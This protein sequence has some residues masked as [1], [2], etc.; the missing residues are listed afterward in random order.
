MNRV[1]FLGLHE[2]RLHVLL[3]VEVGHLVRRLH[4]EERLELGVRDDLATVGGVLEVVVLDVGRDELGHIRASH[5]GVLRHTEE[6]GEFLG[7]RRRLHEATRGTRA[8]V[9]V[10]LG[11]GLVHGAG[12]LEHLLLKGLEVALELV[13]RKGESLDALGET[14]EDF[15]HGALNG[16]DRLFR[17]HFH[18]FYYRRRSRGGRRRGLR[19]LLHRLGG[20]SL[21]RSL[22][23]LLRIGGFDRRSHVCFYTLYRCYVFK[24]FLT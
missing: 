5:L 19:G 18:V 20:G 12:F 15:T 11:V 17:R 23:R 2:V 14:S 9:A 3:K 6:L 4:L 7:D 22:R 8:L 24:L 16:D 1:W 10:T 13:E 21:R